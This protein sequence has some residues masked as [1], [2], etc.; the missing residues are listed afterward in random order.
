MAMK[1]AAESAAQNCTIHG[2]FGYA[3]PIISPASDETAEPDS[4]QQGEDK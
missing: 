3:Q 4:N 2:A 1:L